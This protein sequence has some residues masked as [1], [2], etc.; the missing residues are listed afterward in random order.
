MNKSKTHIIYLSITL[1][2]IFQS[3]MGF[4]QHDTDSVFYLKGRVI[5]DNNLQGLSNVHVIN[6]TLKTATISGYDG[7]FKL[8]A[9]AG[10]SLFISMIGY[11][12][13]KIIVQPEYAKGF[14]KMI[15]KMNFDIVNMEPITILGKTYSQ[16]R[17]DFKSLHIEPIT[18]NQLEIDKMNKELKEL[19]YQ[20][21]Q[22][23]LSPIQYLYDRFNKKARLRRK[24]L[25]ERAKWN[26]SELF[27]DFPL[28]P[29]F[30]PEIEW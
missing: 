7:S 25:R 30:I 11:K 8:P 26:D 29:N 16:F 9:M 21:R 19:S 14:Y 4:S 5:D 13:K 20:Y 15:V 17:E 3:F 6:K 12:K 10:D 22:A 18:L 28:D 24:M 2:F 23:V 1:W 27:K